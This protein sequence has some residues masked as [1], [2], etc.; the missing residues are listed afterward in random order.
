LDNDLTKS[1]KIGTPLYRDPNVP[2]G[3]Y[4]KKCDI[5]SMGLVFDT[6]FRGKSIL[7]ATSQ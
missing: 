1:K 7:E 6:I 3:N 5:Y 2:S 4:T